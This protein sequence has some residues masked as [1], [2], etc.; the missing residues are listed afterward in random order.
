MTII[1]KDGKV[2]HS[3]A[4]SHFRGIKDNSGIPVLNRAANVLKE[5]NCRFSET[6]VPPYGC[7]NTEAGIK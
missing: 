7:Q 2:V 4:A 5:C 3:G 1:S 6:D